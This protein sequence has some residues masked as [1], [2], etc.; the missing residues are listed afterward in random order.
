[1]IELR[2]IK[3]FDGTVL[4][5]QYRIIPA[6]IGWVASDDKPVFM[7]KEP[8]S[9]SMEKNWSR[10]MDVPIAPYNG[11]D[12]QSETIEIEQATLEEFINE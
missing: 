11:V 9:L 1:M 3:S 2:Q 7:P 6:C 10:W 12:M 4:N 8:I 5:L